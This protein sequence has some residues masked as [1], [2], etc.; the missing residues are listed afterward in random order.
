[1]E[2]STDLPADIGLKSV[3]QAPRPRDL[4]SM[5]KGVDQRR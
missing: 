1:M 3:G 5:W 2:V 4:D